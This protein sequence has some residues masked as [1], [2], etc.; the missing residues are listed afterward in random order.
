MDF[1]KMSVDEIIDFLFTQSKN[2]YVFST[3]DLSNA[4]DACSVV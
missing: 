1:S 3:T 2:G 4:L